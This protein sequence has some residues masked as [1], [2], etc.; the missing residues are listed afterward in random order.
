[1]DGLRW[2]ELVKWWEDASKSADPEKDLYI[3]LRDSLASKPE[4]R[5]FRHYFE[6]L[7]PSGHENLPA[8]IPQ[9]YLHYDPYTLRQQPDGSSL[10][11]QRMDFLLL[12]P[13]RQ[14]VVIEID[15][16]QHYADGDK[17]S[18]ARYATM[19]AEDR[20]LRLLGYEVYRFAG[21]ELLQA[22][23][24]DI[25]ESFLTRLIAGKS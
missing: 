2:K 17:A 5:F 13:H 8:L 24:R 7:R 23:S 3:R 4:Q 1:M 15:G 9:V 25:V 19:V 11:R 21:H 22:N 6:I 20:N 14:R 12:L 18:P 10:V 16:Q